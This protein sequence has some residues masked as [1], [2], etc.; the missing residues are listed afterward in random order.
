MGPYYVEIQ[1]IPVF[2]KSESVFEKL[3]T[4]FV[5]MRLNFVKKPHLRLSDFL[6]TCLN[7]VFSIFIVTTTHGYPCMLKSRKY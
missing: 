2:V 4:K 5:K 7:E 1:F 3:S 6:F